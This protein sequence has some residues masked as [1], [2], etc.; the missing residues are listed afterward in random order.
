MSRLQPIAF[1]LLFHVTASIISQQDG[2]E[3]VGNDESFFGAIAIAIT[4][5]INTF[6]CP[7]G[8]MRVQ[9]KASTLPT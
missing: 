4:V 2:I 1:Q 5:R 6:S 7:L 8:E 3:Q 9:I